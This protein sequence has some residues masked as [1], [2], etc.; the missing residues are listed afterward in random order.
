MFSD[1][2]KGLDTNQ[3]ETLFKDLTSSFNE[4]DT[5]K[6]IFRIVDVIFT[7][8]FSYFASKVIHIVS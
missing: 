6:L 2:F 1:F 7:I 4:K 3:I 5:S 8:T